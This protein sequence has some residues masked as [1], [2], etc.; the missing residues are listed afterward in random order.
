LI[1]PS[2][3]AVVFGK[4]INQGATVFI[5]EENLDVSQAV[6][7][8]S[9]IGWYAP[10]SVSTHPDRSVSVN[11]GILSISQSSFLNATGPW[12]R[13]DS[14]NNRLDVAFYV[15]EPR[16]NLQVVT[17]DDHYNIN[18]TVASGTKMTF[19]LDTN[20]VLSNGKRSN[21]LGSPINNTYTGNGFINIH[22]NTYTKL[23]GSD[24]SLEKLFV[25]TTNYYYWDGVWDTSNAMFSH[26][27]DP[28][29]IYV[30]S[31]LNN[32]EISSPTRQLFIADD[33]LS[34][35]I[36]NSVVSRGKSF[37]VSIIG[38]PQ[39]NYKLQ[40]TKPKTTSGETI[41]PPTIRNDTEGVGL[42]GVIATDDSGLRTVSFLTS[43]D[44]SS[45]KF[46]IRVDDISDT[47]KFDEVE[48]SVGKGGIT[49]V[50][51]S[52]QLT[53]TGEVITLSGTNTESPITYLFLYGPNLNYEGAR[54]DSGNPRNNPVINGDAST[55]K[56]VAVEGDGSW[57]W[58]WDTAMPLD[59]GTYTI[60]AVSQPRS[61]S[62]LIDTAYATLSINLKKPTLSAIIS[63]P[64]V[65]KGD[66]LYI[67]GYAEG[68]PSE[69]AIWIMGKNYA[70]RYTTPVDAGS[71]FDYE[72]TRQD[73]E[74]MSSGQYYVIVQ[75]PMQNGKFDIVLNSDG[76]ISNMM[77]GNESSGGTRIFQ[78][79]GSGSLQGTDAAA[80]LINAINDQYID[81]MYAKLQFTIAGPFIAIDT[82]GAKYIGDKITI[83]GKT[84]LAIGTNLLVDVVPLVF[85]PTNKT[86]TN[87]YSSGAIM[88]T[89][90]IKG[91][92]EV[93]K[94]NTSLDISTFR[95]D[96]YLVT[97]SATTGN[98][99]VDTTT[100]II[101]GDPRPIVT[102]NV[103]V[104]ETPVITVVVTAPPVIQP[105]P[106]PTPPPVITTNKPT[107]GYGAIMALVGLIV[108]AFIIVRRK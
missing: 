19:K 52:S 59:V 104:K 4:Y 70:N 86:E 37:T 55:F 98:A 31:N 79:T 76:S 106:T 57:E 89:S 9:Y 108:V 102:Q 10:G 39:H 73:T 29:T 15:E 50:S 34:M 100:F 7:T 69:L 67:T 65:A 87:F 33:V 68:D 56:Q 78:F 8:S 36:S 26:N 12:Y 28:Y 90:V 20:M 103:T 49:I 75:H 53:Y 3:S 83:T 46:T 13:L 14:S 24:V 27:T 22:V 88:A 32:L 81:D 94:F 41:I 47:S 58:D 71:A 96:E 63:Q 105:V 66:I 97:V 18:N 95:P 93:N 64:S 38:K 44:T 61:K 72:I 54:I 91:D 17:K 48:I 6:D 107:P 51:S 40:V 74:S 30:N 80:A 2:V 43:V 16:L 23:A 1:A 21:V 62:N 45:K 85:K 84:N 5:G 101:S 35:T 11:G 42:N 82:V 77:L 99:I 92:D 60:F 25:N